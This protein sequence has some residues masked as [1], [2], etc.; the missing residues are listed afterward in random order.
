MTE[1]KKDSID[2]TAP[3]AWSRQLIQAESA[4]VSCALCPRLVQHRQQAARRRPR[5]RR[6]EDYWAAPVPGF[7]DPLARVLILGLAPSA[8][9]GNRTGRSFTGNRSADWLIAAMHRTGFANRP[10]SEHRFDGLCLDD[11]WLMSAVR[12]APPENKPTEAERS[13]CAVH[14][15]ST[16][17][18]LPCLKVV[19]ALGAFAWSA[20]HA[21]L[22]DGATPRFAHEA[23]SRGRG[24]LLLASYHPSPQNTATGRLT[25]AMT[26]SALVRARAL[27][28]G[29]SQGE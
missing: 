9:G 13:R 2:R 14:L 12:C 19:V 8:D 22:S 26:D 29:Y 21:A 20:A 10:R 23:E 24:L 7:G 18:A 25:A 1:A 3:T 17:A 6:D 28:D 15:E 11:V 27:A 16:I 4:A 5:S